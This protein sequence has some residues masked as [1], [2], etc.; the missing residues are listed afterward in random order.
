MTHDGAF[1]SRPHGWQDG[2]GDDKPRPKL[3][4][5][6]CKGLV[7]LTL[8]IAPACWSW[9]FPD[10]LLLAD[11]GALDGAQLLDVLPTDGA[12]GSHRDGGIGGV[13]GTDANGG[14]GGAG[15]SGTGGSAGQVKCDPPCQKDLPICGYDG[16][17]R[18][19]TSD[20]ECGGKTCNKGKCAGNN[21]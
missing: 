14:R 21:S 5:A 7:L 20:D 19:C 13:G 11:G 12:A 10:E 4:R 9:K 3:L 15:G 16:M 8:A 17:C 1:R 18:A 2:P 6:A